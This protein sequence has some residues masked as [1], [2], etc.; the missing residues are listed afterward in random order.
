MRQDAVGPSREPRDGLDANWHA[1]LEACDARAVLL[2]NHLETTIDIIRRCDPAA[3]ILTGG[4]NIAAVSGQYTARDAIEAM[5]LDHARKR[6]KPLVGICRGLQVLLADDNVN[7]LPVPGHVGT[8]HLIEVEGRQHRVNSFH[9]YG[10]TTSCLVNY[11]ILARASDGVVEMIRH[12][13]LPWLGLGWHP[14]RQNPF[15]PIDRAIIAKG[16]R[17]QK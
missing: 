1:L 12:Q 17:G 15:D 9:E 16:I 11:Q 2:P 4:G 3:F 5:I 8:T 14:E 7:V 13:E 10:V 6:Q